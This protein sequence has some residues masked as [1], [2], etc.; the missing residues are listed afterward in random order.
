MY[1]ISIETSYD[2]IFLNPV[3]ICGTIGKQVS[4]WWLAANSGGGAYE[5]MY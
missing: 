1:T 2:L 5:N 4:L 3:S